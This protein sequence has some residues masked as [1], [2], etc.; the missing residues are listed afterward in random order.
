MT[1]AKSASKRGQYARSEDTRARILQAAMHL[2]DNS[3]F[4]S[5]SVAAIAREAGVAM[6]ILNYHF[7]SKQQLLT[8]MMR[9]RME[10]FVSRLTPRGEGEDFF[11]YEHSLLRAY[12]DYLQDNPTFARLAEEVRHL[13]PELYRLG[14]SAHVDEIASRLRSGIEQGE[15]RPMDE[16]EVLAQAYLLQ[17]A[18]SFLDRCLEDERFMG[19]DRLLAAVENLLRGGL[20]VQPALAKTRRK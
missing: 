19:N 2:A 4:Q 6:G 16:A 13:A 9:A 12:L 15:L 3:G 8:E 20:A 11:T 10:D 14:V 17:G 1:E 5:I 7:G 18:Y